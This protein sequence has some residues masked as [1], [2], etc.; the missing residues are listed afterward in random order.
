MAELVP[1]TQRHYGPYEPVLRM[2][3][4]IAKSS[5][6]SPRV[7]EIGPGGAPFPA[8]T[9]LVDWQDWPNLAG[10]S[11][12]ALDINQDRLPYEDKSIDFVYC[13][14]TLEDIYNPVGICREMNRVGR[15][16]YIE[17]PSPIAELVRGVEPGNHPWR[18]YIHHR[19][20]F[21]NDD[22]VLTFVQK[23]PM[24]EYL[25]FSGEDKL[26]ELLNAGPLHWNTY[27]LWEG[28][29][30]FRLLQHDLD[31]KLQSNYPDVLGRAVQKTFESNTAL[32]KRLISEGNA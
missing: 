15:A 29:L 6:A 20:F 31:F 27:F 23:A 26:I 1:P 21:W 9:D 14:H 22:G 8:A 24:I 7:L 25:D 32:A 16:G 19:S 3:T 18:G 2:V 28:E 11:V 10:R 13:R 12:H 17:T 4:K 5:A 30:K